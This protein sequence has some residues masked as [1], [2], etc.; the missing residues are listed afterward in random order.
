MRCAYKQVR[1]VALSSNMAAVARE[2]EKEE[3]GGW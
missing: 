2:A 3:F 1:V